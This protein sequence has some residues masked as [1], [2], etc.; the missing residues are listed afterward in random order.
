[1]TIVTTFI[2]ILGD[3][4]WWLVSTC[5]L[6][7][8]LSSFGHARAGDTTD[9]GA[10]IE[11]LQAAK[12]RDLSQANDSSVSPARRNDCAGHAEM[13]DL[14]IRQMEHG[15]A[16]PKEEIEEALEVPPKSVRAQKQKLLALLREVQ[17]RQHAEEK[18][19]YGD[20]QV[21][22]DRLR[23]R[24]AQTSKVIETLEIDEFVP[25]SEIVRA[26]DNDKY[27]GTSASSKQ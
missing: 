11:M 5:A 1:L 8:S 12:Q 4:P 16:V 26:L 3:W 6:A 18:L 17:E 2:R 14:A 13:A 19:N 23:V 10:T 21:G 27:A 25:W 7:I 20:N 9:T 15:Y 24:E 22:L